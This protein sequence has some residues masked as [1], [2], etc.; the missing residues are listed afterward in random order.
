M[1]ESSV[2][3]RRP[4]A[5]IALGRSKVLGSQETPHLL[6]TVCTA[7]LMSLGTHKPTVCLVLM[8]DI[9]DRTF[10]N[11]F[12]ENYDDEEDEEKQETLTPR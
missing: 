3:V 2:Q 5:L 11:L 8:W 9:V 4:Q 6:Y 12:A 1:P 10:L 7:V